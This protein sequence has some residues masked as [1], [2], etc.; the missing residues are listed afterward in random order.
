[1][2]TA[3]DEDEGS[4]WSQRGFVVA[5]A[6]VAV[7]AI[8]AVALA[9]SGNDEPS[10]GAGAKAPAP[11][12]PRAKGDE[13]ACNTSTAGSQKPLTA[14]PANTKWELLGRIA[15]PTA[16]RTYGPGRRSGGVP[17]CFARSA[18][19]ALYGAANISVAASS[20]DRQTQLGTAKQSFAPGPGRDRVLA[21]GYESPDPD[22]SVQ[23]AGFRF[24]KYSST[25]AVIDLAL[26]ASTGSQAGYGHLP[27]AMRWS[28]GDW[29]L[30]V[31]DTGDVSAGTEQLSD[32]SGYIRW[33]GAGA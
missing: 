15:V 17:S 2:P 8:L 28:E 18:E 27:V 21:K 12:A 31:P 1:M 3:G 10:S 13:T 30:S 7:V 14:A 23:I 25:S 9:L 22:A 11:K 20:A 32:L 24:E 5:A 19:G 6:A 4:I 29:K 33:A 16:P 26:K